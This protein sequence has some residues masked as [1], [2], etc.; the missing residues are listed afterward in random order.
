M[1]VVPCSVGSEEVAVHEEKDGNWGGGIVPPNLG[2]RGPARSEE[3]SLE[4]QTSIFERG[5]TS[6]AEVARVEEQ[7]RPAIHEPK[8]KATQA[9]ET[10]LRES[11]ETD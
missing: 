4:T 6:T 2:V 8:S 9:T 5:V 3:R 10:R 7:E 1:E 11:K